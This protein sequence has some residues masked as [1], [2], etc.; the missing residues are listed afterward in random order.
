M[1]SL[2]FLFSRLECGRSHRHTATVRASAVEKVLHSPHVL[3]FLLLLNRVPGQFISW[4]SPLPLG[5]AFGL[6]VCPR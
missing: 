5:D 2:P 6:P 4:G 3:P 1:G